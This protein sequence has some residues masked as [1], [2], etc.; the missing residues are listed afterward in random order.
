[1]YFV[2]DR[3]VLTWGGYSI[4]NAT[5]QAMHL[6]VQLAI[7]YDYVVTLSGTTYP[8]KSNTYIKQVLT[9]DPH[10]LY[11]DLLSKPFRP[12]AHLWHQY[13]ECDDALHRIARFSLPRGINM[14]QGSQWFALP[15]D[16][17]QWLLS[18]KL[19][20]EFAEY[21]QYIVVPDENFFSTLVINSPY[22]SRPRQNSLTF[23]LFDQWENE[24]VGGDMKKCVGWGNKSCG[25]SPLTL[26]YT[27]HKHLVQASWALFARKFDPSLQ[28][29]MR[30]I[31]YIDKKRGHVDPAERAM[32]DSN[33]SHDDQQAVAIRVLKNSHCLQIDKQGNKLS[34]Q[35]CTRKLNQQFAT[36]RSPFHLHIE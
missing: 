1:M 6:L 34:A 10:M 15:R 2:Q 36:S 20:S 35:V 32:W 27:E 14:Y 13:I 19:T 3:Q 9:R 8:I 31:D 29:S 28:D 12:P 24:K 26:T 4:V 5:L 11:M 33:R 17:V 21:A 22:C 25:R 30:L 18:S 23:L 16:V 7:P